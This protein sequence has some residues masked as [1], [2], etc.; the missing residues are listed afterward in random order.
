M[1][2]TTANNLDF[3]SSTGAN[4]PNAFLGNWASNGAKMEYSGTLTPASD[5]YRLGGKGSSGLLG[6]VGTNKLTG[7][8][9]LIVG[10]TG[11]S[12]IRVMLA[13]AN[14]FTG[15]TVINTGARLTLGN[16]LALQNS[17]LDVGSAG[18]N[19]ALQQRRHRHRSRGRHQPDLRRPQGQPQPALRFS[20]TPAAT[21]KPTSPPPPSPASPSI[22]ASGKSHTYS[23]AIADFATGTTLTKTGLGTQ[24]LAGANTYT[25]ATTVNQGKLFVNGSLGNTAVALNVN[26]RSHPRRH[27]HHR[28]RRHHRRRRQAGVRHQH[29]PPPATTGS[30]FP[31]AGRS[32]SPALR[33]SPSPPAA[34]P[35]PGTYTLITGG[36]NITGVAPATLNLPS[37]WVATVSIS[38]NSLLL[39][40]TS[41]VGDNTPPTLVSIADDK[42]GGTGPRQHPSPTP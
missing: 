23:G 41:T 4:L 36:N 8:R 21:T 18:G 31:P 9:G 6:I 32:P 13:G 19:F 33:N 35:L 15:D 7:T 29:R 22:P 42:S 5:A 26:C 39:N 20:P 34:A 17:A 38:G 10:G 37:N 14:D 1:T 25:G 2:G 11:A 40:L 24:I 28:P 30:T 27:R 3:S 16:N 12:G